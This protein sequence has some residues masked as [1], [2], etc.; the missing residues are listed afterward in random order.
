MN[1]L[2]V[3]IED[4]DKAPYIKL[5][6]LRITSSE[7]KVTFYAINTN[8]VRLGPM[9]HGNIRT[10]EQIKTDVS[11]ICKFC[12]IYMY[13][14]VFKQKFSVNSISKNYSNDPALF[15]RN[16]FRSF[17]KDMQ[18][19]NWPQFYPILFLSSMIC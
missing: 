8:T 17:S 11:S 4:R 16:W 14:E 5:L 19:A 15:L 2:Y 1:F 6:N 10:E 12:A 3:D 7:E 9:F 13:V 18:W